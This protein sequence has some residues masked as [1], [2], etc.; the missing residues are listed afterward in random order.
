MTA[1]TQPPSRTGARAPHARP[2]DRRTVTILF[3]DVVGSTAS[4]ARSDLEAGY[5]MLS[6]AVEIV[7]AMVNRHGGT[8]NKLLG[9]GVLATF[10]APVM[11]EDHAIRAC[12]CALAIQEVL[13]DT[14][15]SA[16]I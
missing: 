8:I 12:R 15:I 6:P 11:L 9:D 16:R 10:G 5:A 4:T 7:V 3:A 1:T 14:N 2:R 13:R